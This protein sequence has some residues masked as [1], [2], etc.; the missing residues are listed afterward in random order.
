MLKAQ[1]LPCFDLEYTR[2]EGYRS[3]SEFLLDAARKRL[4]DFQK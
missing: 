4:E 2:E 3:V 1:P